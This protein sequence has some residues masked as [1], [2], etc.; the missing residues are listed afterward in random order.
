MLNKETIYKTNYG[1]ITYEEKAQRNL[2]KELKILT[3]I[4]TIQ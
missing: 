1:K 2:Q 3:N 4:T